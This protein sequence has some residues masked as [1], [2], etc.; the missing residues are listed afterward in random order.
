MSTRI[1]IATAKTFLQ[2]VRCDGFDF[3]VGGEGTDIWLQ[4]TSILP[5]MDTGEK[6]IQRGRKWRLSAYMTKSEVVQTALMAVIAFME[7]EIR[8][9]FFYKGKRI[10]G[11]H[12]D[13]DTLVAVSDSTSKR[14]PEM[15]LNL[16]AG[17]VALIQSDAAYKALLARSEVTDD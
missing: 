14:E 4:V 12:L 8:E 10:F 6:K 13:I 2:D 16:D 5:D 7:H 3:R 17:N 9:R 11:P 15:R 1:D